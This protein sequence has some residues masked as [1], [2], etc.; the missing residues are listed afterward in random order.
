MKQRNYME[1]GFAP[2]MGMFF[3]VKDDLEYIYIGNEQE[4]R[5]KLRGEKGNILY[6]YKQAIGSWLIDLRKIRDSE[7][8]NAI[9]DLYNAAHYMNHG[10]RDIKEYFGNSKVA[11]EERRVGQDFLE[12]KM[13][14]GNPINQYIALRIWNEYKDVR[15]DKKG[16]E[17]AEF[18]I[19]AMNLVRPLCALED[20]K[21]EENF[22]I[23]KQSQ[24]WN[25]G[26]ALLDHDNTQYVATT[27]DGKEYTCAMWSL[28]PVRSYYLNK[29]EEQKKCVIK[30]KGCGQTFI[31]PSLRFQLCSDV[32]RDRAINSNRAQRDDSSLSAKIDKLSRREYQHWANHIKMAEHSTDWSAQDIEMLKKEMKLF[33][34]RKNNKN[35]SC[36]RG[37]LRYNDL[38]NWY[39][40]ERNHLDELMY[41]E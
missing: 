22:R 27:E 29:L 31:A 25:W 33:Q 41:Q 20:K 15:E 34:A 35:A 5:A 14:T 36:R 16:L 4:V 37:K 39:M 21:V 8:I 13:A 26:G 2:D 38:M 19:K 7:W 12:G 1:Y 32:C 11:S 10:K 3:A 40:Q 18:R 30:C 6:E 28:Y 24:I 23:N 17:L 9:D